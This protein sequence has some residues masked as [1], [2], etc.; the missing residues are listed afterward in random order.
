VKMT[1]ADVVWVRNGNVRIEHHGSGWQRLPGESWMPATALGAYGRG[2]RAPRD[3]QLL[4]MFIL[5]NTLVVRDGV[6]PQAAHRA[7]LKIDDY[8]RA[9]SPDAS[10][11][12]AA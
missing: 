12:D 4:A 10:G 5:F 8:R 3:R 7:F 11:A 2:A 9:I 1:E 6:D